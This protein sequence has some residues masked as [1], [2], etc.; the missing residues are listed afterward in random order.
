MKTGPVFHS[1]AVL[2]HISN[3]FSLA[4]KVPI[5][6]NCLTLQAYHFLVDW[7]VFYD[8]PKRPLVVDVGSGNRLINNI[9]RLCYP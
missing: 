6:Y 3:Q 1:N 5:A 4:A 8:D 9:I 2:E 7:G